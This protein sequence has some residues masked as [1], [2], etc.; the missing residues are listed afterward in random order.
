MYDITNRFLGFGLG[1][2]EDEMECNGMDLACIF[3][4]GNK[5]VMGGGLVIAVW[6]YI[7]W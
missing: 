2:G 4:A 3:L 6:L 7:A 5:G 1:E